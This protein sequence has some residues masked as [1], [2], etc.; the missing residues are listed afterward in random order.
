MFFHDTEI[1]LQRPVCVSTDRVAVVDDRY[2]DTSAAI[3]TCGITEFPFPP[4][5]LEGLYQHDQS[6]WV[7][8]YEYNMDT[9]RF[10]SFDGI[11]PT[12]KYND[13]F[14]D[15]HHG[16]VFE[17][18]QAV[19]DVKQLHES[20]CAWVR[21]AEKMG[22]AQDMFTVPS[23]QGHNRTDAAPI[24]VSRIFRIV[25]DPVLDYNPV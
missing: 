20:F 5:I 12:A 3:Y 25:Q 11:I 24:T 23:W 17:Y 6:K 15:Y 1:L 8:Y 21:D 22:T 14:E 13:M 10:E 4:L 18:K 2:E 7:Q 9:I 19:K 16:G